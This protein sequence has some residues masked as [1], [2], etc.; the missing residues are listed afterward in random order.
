MKTPLELRYFAAV[1]QHRP[2]PRPHDGRRAQPGINSCVGATLQDYD[3]YVGLGRN[4][5]TGTAWVPVPLDQDEVDAIIREG[6]EPRYV[7]TALGL[8]AAERLSGRRESVPLGCGQWRPWTDVRQ[9]IATV[10]GLDRCIQAS[11]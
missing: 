6:S 11:L 4:R 9:P 7:A 1:R 2:W 3:L 5:G 10:R 8:L